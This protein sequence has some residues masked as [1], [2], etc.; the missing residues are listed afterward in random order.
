[1]TKKELCALMHDMFGVPI[2]I[3]ESEDLRTYIQ[4]SIDVGELVA[5]IRQQFGIDL[6]LHDFQD[7]STLSDVINM[8]HKKEK[9]T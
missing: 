8:I 3:S 6:E 4:D 5:E 2:D 1:M 9:I 7:V